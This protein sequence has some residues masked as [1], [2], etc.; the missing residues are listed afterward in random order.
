MSDGNTSA[1]E[2]KLPTESDSYKH[3]GTNQLVIK[4]TLLNVMYPIV[5]LLTRLLK[6]LRAEKDSK[7]M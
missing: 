2:N 1:A 5:G 4:N 6:D 7:I 3:P